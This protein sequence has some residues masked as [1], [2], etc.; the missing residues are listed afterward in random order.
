MKET[1]TRAA[2]TRIVFWCAVLVLGFAQAWSSRMTV[3]N[4][5]I[6]YLDMGDYIFA[7]QW[8]TAISGQWQ[9]LY[10]AVLGL[11]ISTIKPS[12]YWEYPVVHLVVFGIFLFA[13]CCFDRLL[14]EL[15]AL[16]NEGSSVEDLTVPAWAWR[17]IGYTLFLWS[18]ISLVRVTETNPD[19][20]A[21][22]FSLLASSF[23]V[24]IARGRAAWPTFLMLGLVLGLSY[25]TKPIMFPISLVTLT[26]VCFVHVRSR[27][28]TMQ[29]AV[30]ALVFLAVAT[31]FIAA[32]SMNRGRLTFSDAGHYNILLHKAP[33]V[34]WQGDQ[35]SGPLLHPTR[36][37][38]NKPA[39]FEFGGTIGGTYPVWYDATFWYDGAKASY[40]V[41]DFSYIVSHNLAEETSLLVVGLN[42]AMVSSLFILFWVSGRRGLIVKDITGH[43]FLLV[44]VIFG[45]ALY[46]PFHVEPRYVGGF[47]LVGLVSLFFSVRLP[48]TTEARRAI[49]G[50]AV[51]LVLAL[52]SPIGPGAIPKKLSSLFDLVR[53]LDEVRNANAEAADGLR[54]AG[55]H[56]GD[57]IAS[58]EFSICAVRLESC[59]GAATWARLGR[60]KIVSE[61]YYWFEVADTLRNNYWD[62]DFATQQQVLRALQ[63]TGARIV[64]SHQAPRG[65]G[66]ADWLRIGQSDYYFHW[67]N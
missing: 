32:L 17:T 59:E 64:V 56:A 24:S 2:S 60:F 52:I 66:A 23:V 38:F 47:L 67:L 61:V 26:V 10:A 55:L 12:T 7:G 58:L 25:L 16:K 62:S 39:A 48:A 18:T 36:Q 49:T 4:D 50:T 20:L 45:L 8:S 14:S 41:R 57:R 63:Q 51:L 34:H 44:P 1:L 22:A 43:W 46:A 28:T 33:Y 9:P 37:I 42:G 40:H 21:L 65:E 15:I 13:A 31:P 19:M 54:A 3:V 11:A 53:P 27:R 35:S 30:A 6:S 29:F 5:T